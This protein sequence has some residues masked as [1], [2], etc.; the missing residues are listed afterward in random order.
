MVQPSVSSR[1]EQ[2]LRDT[3]LCESMTTNTRNNSVVFFLHF[4]FI[5][6]QLPLMELVNIYEPEIIYSDGDAHAEYT[7]WNSTQ[8][9]AWLYNERFVGYA[10]LTVSSSPHG[11][12]LTCRDHYHPC[13]FHQQMLSQVSSDESPIIFTAKLQKR[14]YESTTTVDKKSWGYRR[15]TNF[16]TDFLTIQP[17]MAACFHCQVGRE[18][19]HF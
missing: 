1:Q 8:F 18:D 6:S 17:H 11:G 16:T 14:K 19:S 10:I 7:Y 5:G 4:C 2:Q 12:Y 15:N 3:G 9:L 13:E